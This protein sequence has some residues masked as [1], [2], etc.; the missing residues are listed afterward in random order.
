VH[1]NPLRYTDPSGHCPWCIAAGVGVLI[2]AGVTYGFQVAANISQD[3]LTV[4]AFTEVN[5]AQVVAGAVAGAVGVATFGAGT[6]VMGTGV[7]GMI[8]SGAVSGAVSGQVER[9]ERAIENVLEGQALTEGLGDPTDMIQDA[10]VGAALAGVGRSIDIARIRTRYPRYYSRYI[11]EGELRAIEE[12]GMLRGGRPGKTF[13]TT[14]VYETSK[15][16][17]SRLSLKIPPEYRVDF[18][19]L[20][21]GSVR[22]PQR[23]QP[24]IRPLKGIPRGFWGR[25]LVR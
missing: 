8:A 11:S 15:E 14:D 5:W 24:W 20:N 17:T 21:P 3:G 7:V 19:I 10:V 1:C 12:T 9:V 13:F 4:E 22:G 23:V 2:G 6:A 16:A 25:I 18:E